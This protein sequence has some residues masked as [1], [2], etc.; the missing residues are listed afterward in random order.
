MGGKGTAK[1]MPFPPIFNGRVL[2]KPNRAMWRAI[3]QNETKRPRLA[4]RT[5]TPAS[6]LAGDPDLGHLARLYC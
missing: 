5:S 1:A 3:L 6:K 2:P 4:S